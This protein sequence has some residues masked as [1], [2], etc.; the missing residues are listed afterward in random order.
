MFNKL[1]RKVLLL[2]MA[3]TTGV[4]LVAFG[5]VYVTTLGLINA[6]NQA[7]LDKISSPIF[8]T[9]DVSPENPPLLTQQPELPPT[10]NE[11]P[12]APPTGNEQPE[13]P[14]PGHEQPELPPTAQGITSV[15]RDAYPDAPSFTLI[16]DKDGEFVAVVSSIQNLV[17]KEQCPEIA[18]TAWESKGQSTLAISGRYWMFKIVPQWVTHQPI[19]TVPPQD[20]RIEGY[21]IVF[22]DITVSVSTLS[23]LLLTLVFVGLGMLVLIFFISWFFAGRSIKPVSEAWEK[24]KQ[25]V[26]DASH[27]LKTPLATMMTNY[28][29]VQANE[30]SS[31]KS[32]QE[33]L[34]HMRIGMDRMSELTNQLL[35]LAQTEYE[36]LLDEKSVFNASTLFADIMQSMDTLARRK[37]LKVLSDLAP[38]TSLQGFEKQTG[39]VFSIL[40]ENALKYADEGGS[41]EVALQREKKHLVVTVRNTGKGIA[42]DDLPRIFDR[43]FRGDAARTSEENSYGLGL[44]IAQAIAQQ[45]G[46]GITATSEENGW[47]EFIFTFEG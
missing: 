25:F 43:F 4:L 5:A 33:W 28:D 21:Q 44:P 34:S 26:A 29:V 10:G 6:E 17:P 7:R 38:E 22:I 9:P 39:Q 8:L 12:E 30:E 46:G 40:Y 41:V 45:I 23:S 37:N 18:K 16:V 13:A 19:T 20:A 35:S 36:E 2:N 27:E 11:Q 42:K 24:Q 15:Y 1:K 31:V 14:P 32:Q 47:T 3:V